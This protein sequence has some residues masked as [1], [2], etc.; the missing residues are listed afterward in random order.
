MDRSKDR[1][2]YEIPFTRYFYK[3]EPTRRLEEIDADLQAKVAKIQSM[4]SEISQ[5]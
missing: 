2:G 5:V 4:L 1:S 3:Y